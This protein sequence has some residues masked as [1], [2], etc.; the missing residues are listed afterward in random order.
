MLSV[1]SNTY[2]AIPDIL[3]PDLQS[4]QHQPLTLRADA[5]LWA[6]LQALPTRSDIKALISKLEA[7][8]HRE[9]VAMK[10]RCPSTHGADGDG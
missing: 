7:T 9:L 4:S 6:L 10:K 8:H 1:A 2:S 3:H 5:E